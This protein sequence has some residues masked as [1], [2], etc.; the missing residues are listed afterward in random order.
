MANAVSKSLPKDNDA[1]NR[2]TLLEQL[3]QT[4]AE[5]RCEISKIEEGYQVRLLSD[6]SRRRPSSFLG[7]RLTLLRRKNPKTPNSRTNMRY[8]KYRECKTSDEFLTKCVESNLGTRREILS[9]LDFD[10]RQ[11]FIKLS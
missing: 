1:S 5:N 9:D 7:K 11:Q 4:L 10:S 6:R 2:H 8:E 3:K